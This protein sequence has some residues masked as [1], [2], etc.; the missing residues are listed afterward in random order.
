MASRYIPKYTVPDGLPEIIH[1]FAYHVIFNKP[2]DLVTFG[3]HYFECLDEVIC[4]PFLKKYITRGKNLKQTTFSGIGQLPT[5]MSEE[6]VSS[7]R[8]SRSITLVI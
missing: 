8:S 7:R 4:T 2:T 6:R 5:R 1:D 3:V